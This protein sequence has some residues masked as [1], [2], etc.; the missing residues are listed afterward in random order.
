MTEVEA[1]ITGDRVETLKNWA[2]VWGDLLHVDMVLHARDGIPE[3]PANLF[4]RRALWEGAV[5]AYGRTAKAGRRQVLIKELLDAL[6]E[7]AK[8]IH[9]DVLEWR[10]KHV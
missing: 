9:R 7:D 4:A 6:G 5:I 10:D 1:R 2:S 3:H 8:R